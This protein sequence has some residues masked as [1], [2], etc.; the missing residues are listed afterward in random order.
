MSAY[1]L[2]PNHKPVR[3]AN[4]QEALDEAYGFACSG[5][6]SVSV[7]LDPVAA[8]RC[9]AL[10][11]VYEIWRTAA[12]SSAFPYLRP[13]VSKAAEDVDYQ[14]EKDSRTIF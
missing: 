6:L 7:V 13:F 3:V 1:V 5:A 4:V 10:Q 9:Y 2:S 8:A 12:F 14:Y 11:T